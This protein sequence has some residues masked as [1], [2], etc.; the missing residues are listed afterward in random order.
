LTSGQVDHNLL[1]ETERL[2]ITHVLPK[3]YSAGRLLKALAAVLQAS[4]QE[5]PKAE[6]RGAGSPRSM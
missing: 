6:A 5:S 2:G 4:P 3:P 1:T